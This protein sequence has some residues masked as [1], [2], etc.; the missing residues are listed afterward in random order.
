MKCDKQGKMTC[1]V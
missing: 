1:Q